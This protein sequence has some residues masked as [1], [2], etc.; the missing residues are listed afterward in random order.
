MERDTGAN[1]HC[2]GN[3][4]TMYKCIKCTCYTP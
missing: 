3:H 4:I 1:Y 2:N